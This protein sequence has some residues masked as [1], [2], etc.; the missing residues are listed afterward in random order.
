MEQETQAG[1]PAWLARARRHK[2]VKE[3]PGEADNPLIVSWFKKVGRPD[4]RHDSSAW[5]GLF[6]TVNLMSEKLE[7][8]PSEDCLVARS[9][10]DWGVPLGHP[11]VGAIGVWPRGNSTW[12]G[13][14]GIVDAVNDDGTVDLLGGNQGDCVCTKKY[15]IKTALG[16]RWPKEVPLPLNGMMQ[17]ADIATPEPEPT[18]LPGRSSDPGP[19]LPPEPT[20]IGHAETKP[21][22]LPLSLLASRA[23]LSALCPRP[24]DAEKALVWTTY[25]DAMCSD[26]G[27]ALF[28]KF[29]VTKQERLRNFVAQ[30]A[31]ESGGFTISRESGNYSAERIMQIFGVGKHSANVTANE[32][33]GLARNGPALF[34]R[35]YGLGNPRKAAELGN[36]EAGDGWTF[37]GSGL[38]QTTGRAAHERF[39]EDIGCAPED[40]HH[41]LNSLHA[42]LLE[43]EEK[44]CNALADRDDIA[45]ITRKING[46]VNGLPDRRAYHAKAKRLLSEHLPSTGP[47]EVALGSEGMSVAEL[48]RRLT[49]AGY[50]V[51]DIDGQF[52]PL[53]ERALVSFQHQHGLPA[54]GI[55]DKATLDALDE[56]GAAQQT[57]PVSADTLRERGS[58]GIRLWDRARN[59]GRWL[60]T[61]VFGVAAGE[62]S[63]LG[64]L[65]QASSMANRV[66]GFFGE[67][68]GDVHNPKTLLL[69]LL[70]ILGVGGLLLAR[71]SSHGI[72]ARVEDAETGVHLGR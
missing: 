70:A 62:A 50:P 41:P 54:T 20:L 59:F 58:R 9:Y 22:V 30:I 67:V 15:Q 72:E 3:G 28:E 55:R 69:V 7:V 49:D 63:G 47:S 4:V 29:D 42:S 48:Q 18:P 65:D 25:V 43:W 33:R 44:G 27:Q 61:M 68:G 51:G 2:G 38:L 53:T 39:A 1:I 45:T 26:A 14:T 36:T 31:H 57:R 10:L 16:W 17:E 23:V 8:P 46:G 35:V 6:V 11:V 34:E 64:V 71:W 60:Y 21:H 40:I 19:M 37:R 12:Q 32:A 66:S 56:V 24:R 13:H 52:G 5:C